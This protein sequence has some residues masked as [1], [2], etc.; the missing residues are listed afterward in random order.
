MGLKEN[1]ENLEHGSALARTDGWSIFW[2]VWRLWIRIRSLSALER[3]LGCA[4][5]CEREREEESNECVSVSEC[6]CVCVCVRMCAYVCLKNGI[7]AGCCWQERQW[8]SDEGTE[9]VK[10]GRER[11]GERVKKGRER[12]GERVREWDS[13]RD[14]K[15]IREREREWNI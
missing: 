7:N 6:V 8:V 14:E 5:V 13:E 4:S 9:R 2:Y 1:G 15:I 11:K 12:K 10:K 3:V